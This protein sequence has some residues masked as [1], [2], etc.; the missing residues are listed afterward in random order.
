MT[1]AIAVMQSQTMRQEARNLEF[2]RFI[3]GAAR[4][5][6]HSATMLTAEPPHDNPRA[7]RLL[8]LALAHTYAGW[9]RLRGEDPDGSQRSGREVGT[10]HREVGT[11]H[12]HRPCRPVPTSA[13][14]R[15]GGGRTAARR[16]VKVLAGPADQLMS[17]DGIPAGQ[18]E[19]VGVTAVQ[20]ITE[21]A[22]VQVWKSHAAAAAA[23][24]SGKRCSQHVRTGLPKAIRSRGQCLTSSSAL[25]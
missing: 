20:G 8:T 10:V 19:P 22:P 14:Q 15:A 23:T 9:G 25:R 6:L 13:S 24:S 4:R 12:G 7:R 2:R 21:Q 16:Q 11:V 17:L 3:S 18:H 5:L 1:G